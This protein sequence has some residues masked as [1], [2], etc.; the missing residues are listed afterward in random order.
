MREPLFSRVR[1]H[2]VD[3]QLYE[4][5][6]EGRAVFLAHA[7]GFH[8]RCW[9]QVVERLP[10]RHVFAIDMRGH[11][12]SEKPEPPYPWHD[13]GLDVAAVA[14]EIGL[15]DAV[16]VGH[17]KGGFA[18]TVAAAQLPGA[19]GALILLDPII[20]ATEV[21]DAM[22]GDQPEHY[23]ARRR[24]NWAS[25]DEMFE[26]FVKRPP[27][28]S[29]DPA[30]LRD[31]CDYGLVPNP[32]GD[33]FV[34]ACPP[35][36]EAAVYGGGSGAGAIYGDLA[37]ILAPVRVVRARERQASGPMAMNSSPTNPELWKRFPRGEDVSLPDKSHLMAMEDPALIADMILE[38]AAL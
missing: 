4:W 15:H 21:Y 35:R 2:G 18:V 23:A 28:D 19:F 9:N 26:S 7:T 29:W 6:G 10:G 27:F 14:R 37:R 1:G 12:L 33:G 30:V 24:N 13:F 32:D 11:G 36:I 8:A 5:P 38:M 3:L 16:G 31:Y 34:L 22:S 17:S 25:P 20:M